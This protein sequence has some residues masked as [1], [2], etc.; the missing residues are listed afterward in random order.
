MEFLII[1]MTYLL[2]FLA[3]FGL[4]WFFQG[5]FFLN[6]FKVKASRGKKVLVKARGPNTDYFSTGK[7][8]DGWLIFKDIDKDVKRIKWNN[9][10]VYRMLNINVVDVD[11]ISN[12]LITRDYSV[13]TGYD[14]KQV[15]H[16]I[17]R[18]MQKPEAYNMK[19]QIQFFIVIGIAIGMALLL[20]NFFDLM[21]MVE[22][23]LNNVGSASG[24]TGEV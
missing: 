11:D 24:E 13:I 6:F 20:F 15:D 2:S 17:N 1:V 7:I 12:S 23:I 14:A 5:D 8:V 16:T 19:E 3:G 22:Q 4:V 21:G 18:A 10:C 9:R